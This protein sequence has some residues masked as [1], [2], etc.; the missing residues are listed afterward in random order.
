M[1]EPLAKRA[2]A[3][4]IGMI[5]SGELVAG[6]ALQEA[7]LGEALN[8]SRTPV[9]EAIKR[10]EAE[11]L[12]ERDGRFLRVRQLSA[13]EVEEI[14]FLRETLEAHGARMATRLPKSTL[15]GMKARIHALMQAGPGEGEEHWRVDNDFH[16]MLADAAGNETLIRT[17]DDLRLRTCMFDHTRVP[18]RFLKGCEEHL[19]IIAALEGGEADR[20]GDLMAGHIRNA[21]DAILGWLTAFNE[22]KSA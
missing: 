11:G 4:I 15:D 17:I 14:F 10:I 22:G 16:R 1:T 8:M 19:A 20:A 13:V 6:D 21:R 12:A 2:H 9:R 3:R 7:K 18:Q 5:F